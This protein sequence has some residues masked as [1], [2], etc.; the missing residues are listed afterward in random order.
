MPAT[1]KLSFWGLTSESRANDLRKHRAPTNNRDICAFSRAKKVAYFHITGTRFLMTTLIPATSEKFCQKMKTVC[2]LKSNPSATLS[3]RTSGTPRISKT[4]TAKCR[5]L[6]APVCV[7]AEP[8]PAVTETEA[9]WTPD[10]W[11]N[12][13]AY[14]QPEYPDEKVLEDVIQQLGSSPPLVFAG[15][16]RALEEKLAQAALGKA[17]LLQVRTGLCCIYEGM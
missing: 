5:K 12:F 10:S 8:V 7:A 9:P 11:K 3:P 15:E 6:V 13:F 1:L 4:T 17:F 14:Q 16:A 2:L